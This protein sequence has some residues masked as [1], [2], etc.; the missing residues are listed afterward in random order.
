MS[1][2]TLV[3]PAFRERY[4]IRRFRD[5]GVIVDLATGTYVRLNVS[6]AE[7]CSILSDSRDLDE[8]SILVSRRLAVARGLADR[9]LSDVMQSLGREGP[10]QQPTGDFRYSPDVRGGYVLTSN[11]TPRLVIDADGTSVR[12]A[13]PDQGLVRAQIYEYLRAIAPKLLFLRSKP[14]IHGAASLVRDGLR[15]ISGESGAGK[16]TTARAFDAAGASLFAEDMLVVGSVEPLGVH[17][18]GEQGINAWA[19]RW[20]LRLAEDPRAELDEFPLRAGDCGEVVPVA[21]IWFIDRS[22]RVPDGDEIRAR[23]LGETEGGLAMMTSLFLGSS[24]AADWRAFLSLAG[25]IAE[26]VPVFE[27]L[28]PAGL[29]RL[30]AAA[31]RYTENSAS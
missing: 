11:G 2:P 3:G 30:K 12:L 15:V 19:D 1:A 4:A 10:R 14:V 18:G 31:Q 28:M 24:A 5:G 23:R 20:A 6:A 27:A 7:I 22:R 9:A 26:A 29:D 25:T 13:L 21:Q 8:A 17:P 16:T